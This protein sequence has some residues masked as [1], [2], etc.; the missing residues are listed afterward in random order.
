MNAMPL[1]VDA[2]TNDVSSVIKHVKYVIE[3][4][5]KHISKLNEAILKID[6]M[7]EPV[8]RHL[9]NNMCDLSGGVYCEVGTWKG[10]SFISA[11]HENKN[12]FGYVID[13][14]SEFDGPIN[15]FYSNIN[16]Y[17]QDQSNIQI[18]N[19][20]C[21]DQISNNEITKPINIYLFDGNHEY[22]SQKLGITHYTPFFQNM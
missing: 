13:N 22:I 5:K 3:Q 1:L 16:K 19:R 18:Y 14:W 9:Y 10:A 2:F 15:D 17:L 12:I 6:G 4:S 20:H 7:S 8:T 11:M 21:F